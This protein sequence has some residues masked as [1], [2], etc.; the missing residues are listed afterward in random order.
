MNYEDNK[1][2]ELE[3]AAV[4]KS[5]IAKTVGIAAGMGVIGAGA[6][7][8]ANSLMDDEEKEVTIEESTDISAEDLVDGASQGA[9][10]TTI[11]EE[12]HITEPHKP[13][14]HGNEGNDN[15]GDDETRLTVDQNVTVVDEEGNVMAS[16]TSGTLDGKAYVVTDYD[17]DGLADEIYYDVN[18]DGEF[19]PDEGGML[20]GSD[21]F[22]MSS[23][24]QAT[25]SVVY[26][27]GGEGDG[28]VEGGGDEDLVK[29]GD[30]DID[31]IDND[32]DEGTDD[33]TT[34]GDE[35]ALYEDDYADNNLD[36]N[37]DADISDFA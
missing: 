36:Y 3:D 37:N 2:E 12:K 28:S 9:N 17:G 13:T 4:K 23:F 30:Q 21:Q 22:A 31:D 15:H 26:I 8:A 24:G 33:N 32:L 10:N 7:V 18:G 14:P 29:P 20:E 16:Q 5:N 6:A 1:V 34:T 25:N 19:T 35:M 27:Q 11:V